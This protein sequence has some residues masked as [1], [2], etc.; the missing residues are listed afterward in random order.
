MKIKLTFQHHEFIE[1][2][3]FDEPGVEKWF[4]HFSKFPSNYYSCS[5]WPPNN[6]WQEFNIDELRTEELF[7]INSL[8]STMLETTKKLNCNISLPEKFNY[9]QNLLNQLH[10]F[11]TSNSKLL[12]YSIIHKI[13]HVVH[14]LERYTFPSTNRIDTLNN[15]TV[16]DIHIRPNRIETD[17]TPWLQFSEHEQKQNYR[18]FEYD[19]DNLVLLDLSILGKCILQSFYDDD[20]PTQPDCTGRLGS[21]GGFI[22]SLNNDRKQIYQSKVFLDWLNQYNLDPS[23]QPYEY[24]IGYVKNKSTELKNFLAS[25]SSFNKIEFIR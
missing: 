4:D 3:L 21:F 1:I 10:R 14:R 9:D 13:N 18:Y 8:W 25:T 2:D 11:F 12:D 23:K 22:I 16:A 20:D 19:I 7:Y 5:A 17:Q 6:Y 15:Y 24:P